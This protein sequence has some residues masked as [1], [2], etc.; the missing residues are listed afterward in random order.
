MLNLKQLLQTQ[1]EFAKSIKAQVRPDQLVFALNIELSELLN[2]LPWKWWK[3]QQTINKEKTLD[4]L[5]DVLAFWFSW[6]NLYFENH[7]KTASILEVDLYEKGVETLETGIMEGIGVTVATDDIFKI[8]YEDIYT[9]VSIHS[10]GRRMGRLI[11]LVMQLTNST[12][13]D[14]KNAYLKKMEINWERQRTNY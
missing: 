5:A 7:R 14:V 12:L 1:N 9:L 2:T 3:T 4:E 11:G 13:D 10:S 8:H 6:Y